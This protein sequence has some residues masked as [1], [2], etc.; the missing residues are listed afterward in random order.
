MPTPLPTVGTAL[1]R[2][3]PLGIHFV[4]LGD[5]KEKILLGAWEAGLG[6][7]AQSLDNVTI[8]PGD[9]YISRMYLSELRYT[10]AHPAA[11]VAAATSIERRGGISLPRSRHYAIYEDKE[12]VYA[13]FDACGVKYPATVIVKT[14]ADVAKCAGLPNGPVVIKSLYGCSSLNM[15]QIVDP[16][17]IAARVPELLET[18]G[19]LVVQQKI[20]CTVEARLTFV[21]NN[22]YHGYYRHRDP[23]AC[24]AAT[25]CGGV[26]DFDI[27][28]TRFAGY[29]QEFRRRTGLDFG[30]LD[31]AW[32]DDD[33]TTEPFVFEVSPIFDVNPPY[34]GPLGYKA[35][36]QTAEYTAD[37]ERMHAVT[38]KL[39]KEYAA[40]LMR[41]PVLFC[42]VDST[43]ND[44]WNRIRRHSSADGKTTSKAAY[45]YVETMKDIPLPLA[46]ES[47]T[48][49]S[50]VYSVRF[51]TARG[52][53]ERAYDATR[54]WLV[55]HGF[56]IGRAH[57]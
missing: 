34:Y 24:S 26:I 21:G 2:P 39:I 54:D 31:V 13:M 12:A 35:Y 50:S 32:A 23:A 5:P 16:A 41:K 48:A 46:V 9:C 25:S 38:A 33:R 57:V 15:T 55:A 3:R 14:P 20:A 51:L 28:L 49:L 10:A 53:Y 11:L 45:S 27:D 29:V 56:Q 6:Q 30:G 19:P 52:G 36:K 37:R 8:K 7:C 17:T 43:V 44:H 22:L 1:L 42:D 18:M 4:R 40:D 47:V